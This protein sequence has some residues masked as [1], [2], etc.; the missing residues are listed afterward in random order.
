MYLI[1]NG[2]IHD[3]EGHVYEHTDLLIDNGKIIRIGKEIEAQEAVVIDAEGKCIFPGMID[4]AST[5]GT[6]AGRGQAAENDE[7]VDPVTPQM[8]AYYAFEPKSMVYQQLWGYG[9]TSAGVMPTDNNVF[10]GYGAVFKAYGKDPESMCVRDHVVMRASV[11]ENPKKKYGSG[12]ME[13]MTRMGIYSLIRRWLDKVHS[14]EEEDK[15]DVRVKA[16]RP[17]VEGQIPLMVSCNTHSDIQ[18]VIRAF[19]NEKT[20]LI[21]SNAYELDESLAGRV[22]GIVLGDLTDG[23][24]VYN[25]KV[26]YKA[27]FSLMKKGMPVA[28]SAF[29]GTGAPGREILLW[30]AHQILA[31]ARLLKVEINSEDVLKM[32]TSVP[33]K[34]LGVQDRIGA[35][36]EG[37]D[38]DLVIWSE[39]PLRSFRAKPLT[40]FI[41]GEIVEDASNE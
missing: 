35:L 22:D 26:D 5:W 27:L 32:I 10:G 6:A 36:K 41:S 17:V 24:N 15:K 29:S 18:H 11:N 23:F 19:E 12:N 20:R 2:M 7:A 3:G 16:L 38:A 40:V 1:K 9:I 33:S 30:N 39:D 31:Q 14:D 37:M 13:P 21:L 8:E 4:M 28:L 25:N 34:L